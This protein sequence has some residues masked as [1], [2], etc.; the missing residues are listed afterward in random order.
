MSGSVSFV[1][2]NTYQSIHEAN[3]KLDRSRSYRKIHDWTI[4]VDVLSGDPDTIDH[5]IFDMQNSTFH[6]QVFKHHAPIRIQGADGRTRWRFASRQQTFGMITCQVTLV[7]RGGSIVTLN[8]DVRTHNYEEAQR[9]RFSEERPQK[10]LGPTPIPNISFGIE[11]E[12]TSS[13]TQTPD[14]V[15]RFITE[16]SGYHVAV[17]TE[18]YALARETY[19]TWKLMS[20]SSIECHI[21]RPDCNAFELVSPILRGAK[22]LHECQKVIDAIRNISCIKVNKSMGFHVHVNVQNVARRDLI[23]IC[24]NFVKYEDSIDSLLP[25]SRRNNNTYCKSNKAAVPGF[26]NRQRHEALARCCSTSLAKLCDTMNPS[27]RE[28]YYKLNLQNIKT[29]RQPTIE[30]R[31]HSATAST[32]KILN[33]IR[34]CTTF[35]ANSIRLKAPSP[36]KSN[37]TETEQLEMLFEYVI[38]DRYLASFYKERRK[39]LREGGDEDDHCCSGCAHGGICRVQKVK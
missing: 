16:W 4:Y 29:G 25:P 33:W 35:V 5:V 3:A 9:F 13:R 1:V 18:E 36:L 24:Q 31:Q 39:R 32:E 28:R 22:G 27:P 14:Q 17:M 19:G 34:F 12:L 26:T 30:F 21:N 2:G 11:L 20:D 8:H 15:A 6:P 37:R 7:G 38:K 23:K 10:T